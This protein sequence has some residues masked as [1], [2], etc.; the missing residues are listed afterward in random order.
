MLCNS[1]I[2]GVTRK[3][4]ELD[5]NEDLTP[6][7]ASPS[8]SEVIPCISTLSVSPAPPATAAAASNS[9]KLFPNYFLGLRLTCPIFQDH[10][11]TIQKNILV[12]A[13]HL[14]KCLTSIKKLHLTCF[15]FHIPPNDFA[16][17]QLA[18][19]CLA[20]CQPKISEMIA[21]YLSNLHVTFDSIGNFG[22][23]VLYISPQNNDILQVIREINY[24]LADEFHRVG[25]FTD[26]KEMSRVNNWNPHLT[27]AKTSADRRNAK[28]LSI[29]KENYE[30]C[31]DLFNDGKTLL[32]EFDRI[33]LL[34]MAEQSEDGYY[35]S[36]GTL[37]MK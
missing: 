11:N 14:K 26:P 24:Y 30:N 37:M 1:E 4:S 2:K 36:Y 9:K 6:A 23:S 22:T 29:K 12:K 20:N 34:S 13:P 3:F 25:L 18:Q 16:T 21:S 33:D 15:V 28:K 31:T 8:V 5:M 17:L 35:K 19:N 27:I 10:V 32:V 7:I